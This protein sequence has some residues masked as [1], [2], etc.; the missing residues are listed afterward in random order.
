MYNRLFSQHESGNKWNHQSW[1]RVAEMCGKGNSGNIIPYIMHRKGMEPLCR[2]VLLS[3]KVILTT[4]R[5]VYEL[6]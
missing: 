2:G 1:R 6:V 4:A 5:C 3:S